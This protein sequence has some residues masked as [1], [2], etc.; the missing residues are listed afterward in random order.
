MDHPKHTAPLLDQ[1][2]QPW[3]RLQTDGWAYFVGSTSAH[4][5]VVLAELSNGH[6][7]WGCLCGQM[8]RPFS[9]AR[10][11]A[12]AMGKRY[13]KR[14]AGRPFA[15]DPTLAKC[16]RCERALAKLKDQGF[17]TPPELWSHAEGLTTAHYWHQAGRVFRAR[18][19][20]ERTHLELQPDLQPLDPG[21]L[22]KKCLSYE[23][24][25]PSD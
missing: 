15:A 12:T 7:L 9:G 18:C 13:G 14:L 2:T 20:V 19:G 10:L 16:G 5:L 11:T 25:A 1:S 21:E 4:Y 24:E 22:C 6:T 3:P 8:P 17:A 23:S